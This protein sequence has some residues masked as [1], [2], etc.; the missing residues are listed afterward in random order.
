LE[1]AFF[2]QINREIDRAVRDRLE[3]LDPESLTPEHLLKRYLLSKGKSEAE[4]ALYL[5]EARALFEGPEGEADRA[6]GE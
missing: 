6:S 2:A 5:E 1:G 3:G 4:L